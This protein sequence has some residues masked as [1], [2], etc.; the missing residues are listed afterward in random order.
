MIVFGVLAALAADSW[1]D[2]RVDRGD[3]REYLARLQSAVAGDTVNFRSILDWMDRKEIALRR[4]DAVL[5]SRGSDLDPDTVLADLT[6]APMFAWNAAPL[7]GM[8]T[9]EDL[10]SSG[11][12][13]LIR[14]RD[15]RGQ[16]IQYYETAET[17]ER[18]IEA[19]RTQYPHISYQLVRFAR[20][21]EPGP[22]G[23]DEYA[24]AEDVEVL[25]DTIRVSELPRHIGAEMNRAL[26]IRGSVT[27][28]RQRAFELLDSIADELESGG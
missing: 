4:L 5:S 18:R 20:S 21:L 26:F 2:S 15:L 7:T 3:E 14:D 16:V 28:L 24:W 23:D 8:A 25:L 27:A 17:E 19:R 9:F 1:N 11:R 22:R 13:R 10:R 12:L 6:A